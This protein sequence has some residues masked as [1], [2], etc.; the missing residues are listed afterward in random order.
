MAGSTAQA[1]DGRPSIRHG[2]ARLV[3]KEKAARAG[4]KK[5][6]HTIFLL[7]LILP[8]PPLVSTAQGEEETALRL[9]E[10]HRGLRLVVVRVEEDVRGRRRRAVVFPAE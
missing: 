10:C 2:T 7:I 9:R 5:K 4:R 8:P 1:N 6:M 3:G